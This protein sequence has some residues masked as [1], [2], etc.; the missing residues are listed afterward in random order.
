MIPINKPNFIAVAFLAFITTF[1]NLCAQPDMKL[2]LPLPPLPPLLLKQLAAAG[3]YTAEAEILRAS[4]N[5]SEK[6][7]PLRGQLAVRDGAVKLLLNSP[8]RRFFAGRMPAID[9]PY[10]LFIPKKKTS[11]TVLEAIDGYVETPVENLEGLVVEKTEV[12]R[13][14]WNGKVAAKF[15]CAVKVE[16]SPP[17]ECLLWTVPEL[18]DFPVRLEQ[19]EGG[20]HT[21]L[22]LKNRKSAAKVPA[23]DF[24]LPDGLKR[25]A[26][27][28]ALM[29]EM[30]SRM[31]A[32]RPRP[33]VGGMPPGGPPG[34]A[35]PGG[36]SPPR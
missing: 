31:T 17:Q 13:E 7:E 28:E 20:V 24:Q 16:T 21:V 15:R 4:T 2:P 30:M 35:P 19:N 1:A 29:S 6:V 8:K 12:S 23:A 11:Y 36:R 10:L 5:Q 32:M 22:R 34:G 26:S 25:Y 14:K 18:S 33:P 27:V 3:D 9:G